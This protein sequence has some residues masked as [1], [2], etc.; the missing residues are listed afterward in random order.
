VIKQGEAI[1]CRTKRWSIARHGTAPVPVEASK[2]RDSPSAQRRPAGS[3][4]L[5]SAS[6]GPAP[7]Y[8]TLGGSM[9]RWRLRVGMAS[10]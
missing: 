2:R 4:G 7:G 10:A 5:S 1:R 3:V 8:G 6:S 9:R